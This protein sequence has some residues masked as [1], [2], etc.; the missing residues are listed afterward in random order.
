MCPEVFHSSSQLMGLQAQLGRLQPVAVVAGVPLQS[1]TV[2]GRLVAVWV[3]LV[4]VVLV[5]LV[6]VGVLVRQDLSI[7]DSLVL[8][9]SLVL[10]PGCLGRVQTVQLRSVPLVGLEVLTLWI[11]VVVLVLVTVGILWILRLLLSCCLL[12]KPLGGSLLLGMG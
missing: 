3:P 11:V 7:L 6:Q 10:C 1:E 9:G 5:R 8:G 12:G 4:E 2:A